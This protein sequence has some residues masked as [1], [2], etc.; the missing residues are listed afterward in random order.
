[1]VKGSMISH[2]EESLVTDWVH[3]KSRLKEFLY[4][5][6]FIAPTVAHGAQE[7]GTTPYQVGQ[8][9]LSSFVAIFEEEV[10]TN[11]LVGQ[12]SRWATAF[13]QRFPLS[14]TVQLHR[15]RA[16]VVQ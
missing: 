14:T 5:H 8:D 10:G 3:E 12:N 4:A 1:M 6:V 13:S 2:F 16:A 7:Y 15:R 11:V 9:Y